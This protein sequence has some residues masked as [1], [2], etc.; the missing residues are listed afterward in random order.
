MGPESATQVVFGDERSCGWAG[1]GLEYKDADL[2]SI[3]L[4]VRG[5]HNWG[6]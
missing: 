1:E 5:S 3:R 4:K 6:I 2:R